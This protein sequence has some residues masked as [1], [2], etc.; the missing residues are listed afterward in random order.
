MQSQSMPGG[1]GLRGVS[2]GSVLLL[3][4]ALLLGGY[5]VLRTLGAVL[6]TADPLKSA[7]A[8]VVLSGDPGE[9]VAFAVKL[10]RDEV[11][12]FVIITETGERIPEVG[13]TISD[14]RAQQAERGGVPAEN[15]LLTQ[16]DAAST[17]EEARAVRAL[18]EESGFKRL[19]IVTD[20]YHTQRTRL[21]FRDAFSGSGVKIMIQPAAGHWYR[22]G[23]WFL[24]LEG[25]R[26]TAIE[27]VKLA[28]FLLGIQR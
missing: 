8:A 17:V 28:A 21:I 16:Q 1:P 10:Y 4:A 15:I 12:R 7:D 6:V 5:L 9:R 11:V 18:V 2:C 22:S 24:S 25:W 26:I 20:P 27:Y 3:M 13:P 19:I 23:T 14:Q